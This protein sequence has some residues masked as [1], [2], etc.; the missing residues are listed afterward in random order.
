MGFDGALIHI[1]QDRVRAAERQQRRLAEEEGHLREWR[2]GAF[3]PH[4]GNE[5]AGPERAAHDAYPGE[6][7]P[8]EERVRRSRRL[9]VDDRGRVPLAFGMPPATDGEFP[10]SDAAAD[11]A[12]ERRGE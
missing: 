6:P 4:E 9:V 11:V 1:G 7:P 5:R 2:A 8:A 10:R 3:D 12:D